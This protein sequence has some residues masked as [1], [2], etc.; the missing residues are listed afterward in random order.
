MTM[1]MTASAS[2]ATRAPVP[3]EPVTTPRAVGQAARDAVQTAR[4]EGVDVPRNAQGVAA[5]AI[6][7]GADPQSVFAGLVTPPP[8]PDGTGEVGTPDSDAISPEEAGDAQTPPAVP[9]P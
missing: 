1:P 9:E 4:S 7:R 6:A 2:A 8:A 5:R 3:R